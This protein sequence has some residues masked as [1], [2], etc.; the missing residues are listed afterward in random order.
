[1]R[2]GDR[3]AIKATYVRKYDLPFDNRGKSVSVMAIKATGTISENPT[4]GK[5]VRVDWTVREDPPREWF[6]YTNQETIWRLN[7]ED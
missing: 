4:G 3:I 6:F 2:A 5:R 1:M 7:L